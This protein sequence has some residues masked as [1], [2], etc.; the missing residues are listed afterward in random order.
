MMRIMLLFLLLLVAACAPQQDGRIKSGRALDQSGNVI[1]GAYS[2][3]RLVEGWDT[4][5]NS[6]EE[7]TDYAP[8][9]GCVRVFLEVKQ[10]DRHALRC[11]AAVVVVWSKSRLDQFDYGLVPAQK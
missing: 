11:K 10:D 8:K 3:Q 1:E 2:F 9:D 7:I 5:I 4:R 6:L